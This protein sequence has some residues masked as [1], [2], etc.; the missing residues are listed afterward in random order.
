MVAA[1]AIPSA[2]KASPS[3]TGMNLGHIARF[4]L[5]DLVM[6]RRNGSDPRW[7]GSSEEHPSGLQSL[8]DLV[9]RVLHDSPTTCMYSLSLHDALPIR[10]AAIAGGTGMSVNDHGGGVGDPQRVQSQPK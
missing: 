5:P 2:C 6:C 8:T 7:R 3:R 4:L 9:C 10:R 1:W